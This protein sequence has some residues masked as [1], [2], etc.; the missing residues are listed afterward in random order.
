MLAKT[1][2]GVR[3]QVTLS[4]LGDS[5]RMSREPQLHVKGGG[6]N[7]KPQEAVTMLQDDGSLTPT[8]HG[9]VNGSESQ[10]GCNNHSRLLL[11]PSLSNKVVHQKLDSQKWAGS[12]SARLEFVL[13]ATT[14]SLKRCPSTS[15]LKLISPKEVGV[16]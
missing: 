4:I 1:F 10:N 14:H 5:L 15:Y 8:N 3:V 6:F 12:T 11:L 2:W 16:S 9:S 7:Q 13:K